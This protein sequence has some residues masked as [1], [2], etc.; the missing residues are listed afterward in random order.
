MSS[1]AS[2]NFPCETDDDINEFFPIVW[3]MSTLGR[4]V[5][6]S[7]SVFSKWKVCDVIETFMSKILF[8]VSNKL[9]DFNARKGE[10][11]IIVV[12]DSTLQLINTIPCQVF[13]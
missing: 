1:T 3:S 4:S 2:Q 11:F 10:K 8:K 9:M 13:V 5:Y 6:C 7:N 12:S